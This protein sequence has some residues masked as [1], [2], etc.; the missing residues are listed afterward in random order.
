MSN[1]YKFL[2]QSGST[3][4]FFAGFY[5]NNY[6]LSNT[7]KFD[8]KSKLSKSFEILDLNYDVYKTSLD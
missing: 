1:S 4:I 7:H 6:F 5:S 2:Y 8:T 3:F